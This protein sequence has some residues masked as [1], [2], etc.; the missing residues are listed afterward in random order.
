[1]NMYLKNFIAVGIF[2][3][4]FLPLSQCS[5]PKLIKPTVP[6][7]QAV[8]SVVD[9][10][11][12]WTTSTIK[13]NLVP[14]NIQEFVTELALVLPLI[15]SLVKFKTIKLTIISLA[16]QTASVF[17]LLFV[18]FMVV[19]IL[20]KPLYGGYVLTLFSIAFS[21]YTLFEWYTNY[22]LYKTRTVSVG[23]QA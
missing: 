5:S 18:V 12:E 19:Y 2:S 7:S 10:K 8:G 14:K 13:F 15:F 17:W 16:L 20:G 3:C 6:E 1:M 4:L 9:K 23:V 11:I 21:I 22:I